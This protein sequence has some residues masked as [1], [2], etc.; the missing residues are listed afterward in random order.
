ML[1]DQAFGPA[2]FTRAAHLIREGGGHDTELSFVIERA[3]LLIGSVRMTPIKIGAID[4]Y[5]LGPIVISPEYKN[6]GLGSRLMVLAIDAAKKHGCSLVL[7]VGDEPYYR[8]FGFVKVD[9]GQM[10]MPAPV[11]PARLLSYELV[12][13]AIESAVGPVRHRLCA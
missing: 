4:G 6:A 12:D 13:G 1:N 8:R 11:D 7:L 5:L 10:H 9:N 2:R 3:G